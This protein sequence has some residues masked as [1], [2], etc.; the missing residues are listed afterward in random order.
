MQDNTL[1]K[2]LEDQIQDF[3]FSKKDDILDCVEQGRFMLDLKK[4]VKP[5]K[6]I[7]TNM[8]NFR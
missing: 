8:S 1:V 6:I 5:Q 2:R 7:R 4:E 3:P